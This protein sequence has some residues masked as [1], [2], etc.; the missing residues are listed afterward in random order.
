[1]SRTALI[2]YNFRVLMFHNW[3]LLVIPIAAS[4]LTTFWTATTQRFRP[5]IP[6]TVVELVSPLLGA[7]LCAHLL[8]A[9]YRSGI[10]A[11]LASKP[12]DIGKV[13]LWRL[14]IAIGLV[15]SLGA[16][17]L[18]AFYFGLEPYP[19][20]PP[21]VAM[22]TSSLFLGLLALT[23][24]T[25][26]RHPLTGF[27]AA[28]L[29]WALDLPAGP[30]L[31]PFLSLKSLSSSFL[32]PGTPPGQPLTDYWWV[33]KIILAVAAIT[34]Y[35][36][37]K[38]LLFTLGSPLTQ[39]KRRRA[40]AWIAGTLSFYILTGAVAKVAFGYTHRGTLFPDDASW[41]RKQFAPYG[42]LPVSAL[43][44]ANFR[45]Y[46]GSIPNGWR[47]QQEGESDTQGDNQQHHRDLEAIV[48]N[49]PD[50][51]W[52][53]SAADLLARFKSRGRGA[54]DVR[55]EA[56]RHLAKRYPDSPYAARALQQI[57]HLY[58][59]A[60]PK[61]RFYDAQARAGY[62]E[63]LKRFPLNEYAFEALHY[64]AESDRRKGDKEAAHRHGKQWVE[65]APVYD[66]LYAW[67][68][69]AELWHDEKNA[70]ETR[71]A[72]ENAFQAIKEFRKAKNAQTIPLSEPR[73][74]R[75]EQDAGGIEKRLRDLQK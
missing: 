4:Q 7:F 16:L 75:I 74:V 43:F 71:K 51:L 69:M 21:L 17:T 63:L 68:F 35:L 27:G 37:H 46:V 38:N 1:M 32:A 73:I 9:E 24:A 15:W 22:A 8:S 66:K 65:T 26:F 2:R 39:R 40:I 10:G 19:L 30:P 14:L 64:L 31:N 33:A 25:L 70:E 18:T 56:Y 11:V 41:F 59:D 29:Y 36:L 67:A 44:G 54:L 53:S 58:A 23:F 45:G 61:G 49:A 50:S 52:A 28:A 20:L 60:D 72:I 5:E 6:S 3:W 55:V 62:E 42:P 34:L 13:V 12:V 48:K 57:A 47:I